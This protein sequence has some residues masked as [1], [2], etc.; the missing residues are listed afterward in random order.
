VTSNPAAV[1]LSSPETPNNSDVAVVAVNA[2]LDLSGAFTFAGVRAVRVLID[3]G[4]KNPDGTEDTSRASVTRIGESF[5]FISAHA[6]A[7]Q[8]AF[9]VTAVVSAAAGLV[10]EES[11]Q[12]EVEPGTPGAAVVTQGRAGQ[13]VLNSTSDPAT[14]AVIR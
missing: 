5:T 14:G 6:Y 9:T 11:L 10:G 1:S 13:T 4:D 7:T 12:V 8:G 3:W 2:A